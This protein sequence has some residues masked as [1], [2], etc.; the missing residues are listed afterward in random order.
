MQNPCASKSG[1]C[2]GSDVCSRC[3]SDA[4]D[5]PCQRSACGERVKVKCSFRNSDFRM[6][7]ESKQ[8]IIYL[9]KTVHFNVLVLDEFRCYEKS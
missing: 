8:S 1:R 5:R 6:I 2:R 3:V 9:C 4:C 7:T